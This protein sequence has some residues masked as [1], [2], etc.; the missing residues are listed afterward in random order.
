MHSFAED[1]QRRIGTEGNRT[2]RDQSL[3]VVYNNFQALERVAIHRPHPSQ[4]CGVFVELELSRIF[5]GTT[6][7]ARLSKNWSADFAS[8]DRPHQHRAV[9]YNIFC[10]QLTNLRGCRLT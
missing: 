7:S 8:L 6:R 2:L 1:F 9:K 3:F 4:K 10:K 5:A